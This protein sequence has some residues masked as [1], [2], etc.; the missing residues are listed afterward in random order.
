MRVAAVLLALL[1]GGCINLPS[2][3]TVTVEGEI[4]LYACQVNGQWV[5][6]TD[7][8]GPDCQPLKVEGL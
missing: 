8:T 3:V 4:R 1:L 7:S 2:E 5:V 6:R